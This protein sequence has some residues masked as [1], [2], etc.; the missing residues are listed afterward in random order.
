MR[1]PTASLDGELNP[2]TTQPDFTRVRAQ[3]LESDNE[4]D[5]SDARVWCKLTKSTPAPPPFRFLGTPTINFEKNDQEDI[6]QFFNKFINDE[7]IDYITNEMNKYANKWS[8]TNSSSSRNVWKPLS[9]DELRIYLALVILQSIVRKPEMRHYWSKNPILETPF[10]AK[11]DQIKKYLHFVDGETY[12]PATHPNPKLNKIFPIYE[13]L[14]ERFQNLCVPEKNI[15]ID[16]SLLLYKGRLG[17][18]QY[19]PLKRAR[20]GIKTYLLCESKSGY[21]YNFVIYTGKGTILD[22]E[23]SAL[24]ISSQVVMTLVKPLLN[25]GYCLTMDNFYNSLQLADLLVS[26]K[27]DVYGTLRAN[28]KEVPKELSTTKILKGEVIGFQRG[29]VAVLKWKDKKEICLL[30]SIHGVETVNLQ[31]RGETISK[32]KLVHEYNNTMGGVYRVDQH[33]ADYTLPRKRGKKYYKKIFFHLFDLAL[34]NSFV[35]Y[36]KT[37]GTKTALEYR[38]DIVKLIM[39]KYHHSEFCSATDR[40]S[41]IPTP[42]RLTGRHFPEYIPGTEKKNNPTRQ[43]ARV[44]DGR[45]KK[46]RRESRY[47]CPDCDVALCVAPCFRVYHTV[48]DI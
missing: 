37:G 9:S 14:V 4:A 21:V 39:E 17:W 34:W 26:K 18:V 10:I 27:T 23:Y 20:F 6:L 28:R 44:R 25:K 46:I 35:L 11:F 32:P 45:G 8:R 36:S 16:E 43:C 5:I 31:K 42:Q 47:Y 12:N 33:L 22:P 1:L 41:V 40:P 19:I 13:R 38:M 29:K 24:P 2:L 15:T 30:S 48:K 3:V 7:I